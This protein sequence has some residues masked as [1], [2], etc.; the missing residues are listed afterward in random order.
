MIEHFALGAALAFI[1]GLCF[2]SFLNVCIY[3]MPRGLSVV[4]PGS[5]CPGC[6]KPIAPYDNVPVLSW[7]MLRGRCRNCKM[8][9]TPRYMFVELLTAVL[10]VA[11]YRLALGVLPAAIKGMVFCFLIVGLI[12]TDAETHLLPDKLTLTGFGLGLV[13]S[14]FVTVPGIFVLQ[15]PAHISWQALALR[16]VADALAGA[17]LGAGFVYIAGLVYLVLRRTEGMGMGDV[18]LMALVGSFLGASLTLFTLLVACL[19]GAI[20]GLVVLAIV[21]AKRRT[22]HSQHHPAQ[23]H[24]RALRSAKLALQGFPIPFGVFLGSAS[25]IAL[26]FG[27]HLFFWYMSLFRTY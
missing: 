13:F 15:A 8:F 16:S 24:E 10:F 19:A 18:K 26:F 2:G 11:S 7:L 20:Y 12:F 6:G 21:Y 3:R 5:M 23:S 9:I 14:V 4:R 27:E 1:L 25:L 17:L 22:R